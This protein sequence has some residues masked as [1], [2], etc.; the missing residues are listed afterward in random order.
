[1]RFFTV[2][3]VLFYAAVIMLVG[4][5]LIVFSLNLLQPQDVIDLLILTQDSANSRIIL[6][7]V[8]LLLILVSFSFAQ[9]ILGRFQ[10][11]KTIA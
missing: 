11:E 1:M 6:G 2:L 7:L 8:G 9:L 4:V 3:G 10:R 5:I